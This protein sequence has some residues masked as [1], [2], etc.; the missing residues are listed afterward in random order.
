MLDGLTLE[1][2]FQETGVPSL[3]KRPI[4]LDIST[5]DRAK[6]RD[7]LVSLGASI[8][9]EFDRHTWMQDPEGNDFCLTDASQRTASVTS[10]VSK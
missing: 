6:E 7:F 5:P 10:D 8:V 2:C 4:H 9:Q 1:I 3:D